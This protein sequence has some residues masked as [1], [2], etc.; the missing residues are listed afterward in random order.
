[1]ENWQI[2]EITEDTFTI[3]AGGDCQEPRAV[4]IKLNEA[5]TDFRD[6]SHFGE[7]LRL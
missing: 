3:M 2:T 6:G 5:L 1:M 4:T 7:A